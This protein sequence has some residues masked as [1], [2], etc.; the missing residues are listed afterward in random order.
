VL[1]HRLD[2]GSPGACVGP[3]LRVRSHGYNSWLS[4]LKVRAPPWSAIQLTL[5]GG[6]AFV[7]VP[8]S[9]CSAAPL[10]K[11]SAT[12][13]AVAGWGLVGSPVRSDLLDKVLPLGRNKRGREP[14]ITQGKHPSCASIPD[15]AQARWRDLPCSSEPIAAHVRGL[16]DSVCGLQACPFSTS[17]S[18]R[19]WT[20]ART[21]GPATSWSIAVSLDQTFVQEAVNTS[22]SPLNVNLVSNIWGG[23]CVWGRFQ[24][25][26]TLHSVQPTLNLFLNR[27]IVGEWGI[28]VWLERDRQT[29][30][31]TERDREHTCT[32]VFTNP[33]TEK[34]F[35]HVKLNCTV[36]ENSWMGSNGNYLSSKRGMDS[37]F[38]GAWFSLRTTAQLP[39]EPMASEGLISLVRPHG[40]WGRWSNLS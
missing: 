36:V 20:N 15:M 32:Y 31:K 39:P 38:Y 16:A 33:W 17:P 23:Q 12:A 13:S 9:L 34:S 22:W 19:C 6:T 18:R 35:L 37:A 25:S 29:D 1:A 24:G 10:P 7:T 27:N 30:G 14:P 21:S 26:L 3:F 28:R 4:V 11:E 8:W 40:E 5:K 2:R